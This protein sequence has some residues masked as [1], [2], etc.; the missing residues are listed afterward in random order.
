MTRLTLDK[1]AK[2]ALRIG[3]V[4]PTFLLSAQLVMAQADNNITAINPPA[5]F[6]T[7]IGQVINFLLKSLLRSLYYSSSVS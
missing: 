2:N 4:V 7:D 3:A 6:A 1:M 5:A